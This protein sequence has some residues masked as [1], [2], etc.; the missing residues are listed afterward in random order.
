[1][2]NSVI[3]GWKRNNRSDLFPICNQISE[4]LA[5][6]GFNVFT[7]GGEGFMKEGNRGA[8]K[9]GCSYGVLVDFLNEGFNGFTNNDIMTSSFSVRKDV[10]MKN[11]DLV[12]F[13]PGGMG[14]LDEFTELMNWI[15][16]GEIKKPKVVL[17]GCDYWSS[18]INWFS[19]NDI[20]FPENCIDIITDDIDEF[21]DFFTRNFIKNGK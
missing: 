3:L 14:T 16:T 2:L 11:K 8:Y 13:F 21:K 5:I 4:I 15:K 6:N 17:I 18:L 9:Y 20:K 10:L 1:M 19:I 12:V 7:G